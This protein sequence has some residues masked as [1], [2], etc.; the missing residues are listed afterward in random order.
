MHAQTRRSPRLAKLPLTNPATD[1][2]TSS[3]ENVQLCCIRCAE[4]FCDDCWL[5]LLE[6]RGDG[7]LTYTC[8]FCRHVNFSDK[9]LTYEKAFCHCCTDAP[10][11]DELESL[12]Y[13]DH[14]LLLQR[15]QQIRVRIP[16]IRV[17]LRFVEYLGNCYMNLDVYRTDDT[18]DLTS[19]SNSLLGRYFKKMPYTLPKTK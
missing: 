19:D 16:H 1:A 3:K 10:S 18:N 13:V 15:E 8:P 17:V 14:K 6:F 2:P 11:E 7:V 4:C 12:Q 5:D 9:L